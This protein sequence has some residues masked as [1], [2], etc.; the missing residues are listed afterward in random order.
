MKYEKDLIKLADVCALL[1]KSDIELEKR[2]LRRENVEAQRRDLTHSILRGDFMPDISN[3]IVTELV[4]Q[5]FDTLTPQE[6]L[7]FVE[8]QTMN[9][10]FSGRMS[11]LYRFLFETAYL[12]MTVE[13]EYR[14]SETRR[15]EIQADVL[16]AFD[17]AVQR[18]PQIGTGTINPDSPEFFTTSIVV[19]L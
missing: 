8:T 19:S 2:G 11:N 13:R 9:G 5:F 10:S 3:E 14:Q 16:R 7:K 4:S 15:E 12:I 18:T 6:L 1:D 17:R